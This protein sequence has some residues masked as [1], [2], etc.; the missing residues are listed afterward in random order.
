MTMAFLDHKKLIRAMEV[1]NLTQKEFAEEIGITDRHVRNLRDKDTDVSVSLLYRMSQ[2]FQVPMEDLLTL[3][4][5][6]D[7]E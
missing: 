1:K 2:V 5:E 3:R 4:D 6:E 7:L